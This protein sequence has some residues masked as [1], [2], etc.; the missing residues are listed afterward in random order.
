MTESFTYEAMPVRVVFGAGRFAELSAEASKL[1]LYR[2][3]VLSTP[4]QSGIAARAADALGAQAC[5]VY[6]EARMHV[7]VETAKAATDYVRRLGAD[8]CVAVGGGSTIG[9]G[10][11][12]ALHTG[13]P[14]IAVPTTYS[15]SEMTPIWGLTEGKHKRT[16]R[17]RAVLA[18]TVLYDPELTLALP[19]SLSGTSGMNAIAHAME[20][21]YAPDTSPIIAMFAEE[22]I[23]CLAAA[24]PMIVRDPADMV[25]RSLA[26]RGAWL[27]GAC[28]GATTM[29]LH[30]KLCHVLGGMLDLPHAPTHAVMLAHC[31]AF[32]L[33]AA[34]A[35]SAVVCRALAT[36]DPAQALTDIAMVVGAPRSLAEL[37]VRS[38]DLPR[39]IDQVLAAPYAN[40]RR[41]T[42]RDLH[43]LLTAALTGTAP[44]LTHKP[45]KC[46][47][48]HPQDV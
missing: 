42:R 33:P 22:G 23:R 44:G 12:I 24:L 27:C 5:G 7:P 2:L 18:R 16:G 29:S 13:L 34:P 14:V 1:T 46:G 31:A 32:N 28:L 40:P 11:A 25:A 41:A 17:D 3:V 26:L 19:A 20:A 35:A 10:K 43:A 4:G 21:L 48:H 6:S 15:G 39:V 47:R 9:L 37:R 8:G 30:H 45:P 36:D 38:T